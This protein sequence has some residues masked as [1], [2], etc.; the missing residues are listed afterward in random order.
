MIKHEELP[1][2]LQ[3]EADEPRRPSVRRNLAAF[4]E[5]QRRE[6]RMNLA[7]V[8]A[9]GLAALAGLAVAIAGSG[10]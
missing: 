2:A 10:R 9:A 8:A 4:R 1:E 3:L 7:L 5:R 6:R